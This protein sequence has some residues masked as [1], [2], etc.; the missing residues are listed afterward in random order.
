MVF[1]KVQTYNFDVFVH[2]FVQTIALAEKNLLYFVLVTDYCCLIESLTEDLKI[3]SRK[4][5]MVHLK[6]SSNFVVFV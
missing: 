1:C 6:N 3:A 2:T 5:L 4:K